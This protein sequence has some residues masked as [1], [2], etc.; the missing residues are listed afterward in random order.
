VKCGEKIRGH[1]RFGILLCLLLAGQWCAAART[2]RRARHYRC[3]ATAFSTR[4]PTQLGVRAQQGIIAA[5]PRVLP[6]GTLV[7]VS[8]AG[9]YSGSYVVTDTG[10]KVIGYHIDIFIPNHAQARRFGKKL[11]MVSVLRWGN[12][13]PNSAAP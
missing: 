10:S 3:E 1:N 9:P 12:L 6:L 11:V 8:G 2:H 13:A 5:D 4:G 7:R